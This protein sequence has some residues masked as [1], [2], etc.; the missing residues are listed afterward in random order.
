MNWLIDLVDKP[1]RRIIGFMSGT[2]TDGI[3]TVVAEVSGSRR[4][5]RVKTLA[6]RTYPYSPEMRRRIFAIYPPNRLSG[7]VITR[8]SFDLGEVFARAA[9][10][11]LAEAGLD[12]AG[13]DL[14]SHHGVFIYHDPANRAR[15]IP[16]AHLEI[17]EPAVIAERTGIPVV[18][19]LRVR[20]VAAG[21]NGSPL[22]S[23][24]D[25]VLFADADRG[26]AVQNIG[27]I[28]NVT[29]LPPNA[30][31]EEIQ[32]FDTGPGNMLLDGLMNR[33]TGGCEG[34][35]RE[36]ERAA[37]GRV[38][39]GL[40]DKLMRSPFI[41][42]CPPKAA[43]RENFGRV[44]LDRVAGWLEERG[45]SEDDTLATATAFTA[46]SIASSYERFLA[47][48]FRIDEVIVG[49]GGT[50]N[51]TLMKMLRERLPAVRWFRHEDFGIDGDAREAISWAVL[52]N[53]S[54]QGLCNNVPSATGAR[55]PVILGKF[56]PGSRRET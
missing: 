50:H 5:T 22:S 3:D 7:R 2:S 48:Q 41:Q 39:P 30:R 42:A 43:G 53:E 13:I 36:G 28:A 12:P 29:G 52:A 21:G 14:I 4:E 55:N 44:F 11:L 6:F 47:P 49:G 40:L 24:V 51:K 54:I 19:D 35:D 46:E 18:A 26:R 20:D 56:V 1:V 9:L 10:D 17:G 31:L 23:Y 15:G 45:L 32:S 37:H 25:W 27:G 16:G 33:F 38:D 8:L 34:F